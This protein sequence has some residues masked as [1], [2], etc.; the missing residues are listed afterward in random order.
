MVNDPQFSQLKGP[1]LGL[2]LLERAEE[3]IRDDELLIPLILQ[4][5]Q[6]I[7]DLFR[8][9]E[10]CFGEVLAALFEEQEHLTVVEGKTDISH[11]A[12]LKAQ[13]TVSR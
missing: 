1:V 13:P 7:L 9:V 8:L 10:P 4:V 12:L 6:L 2:P 11:F 5:C 3:C